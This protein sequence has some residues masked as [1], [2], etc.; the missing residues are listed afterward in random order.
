M[1]GDDDWIPVHSQCGPRQGV[2]NLNIKFSKPVDIGAKQAKYLNSKATFLVKFNNLRQSGEYQEIM[3]KLERWVEH[4][5]DALWSQRKK[6][7]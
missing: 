2:E 4:N 1:V 6:S 3:I 7:L 5:I